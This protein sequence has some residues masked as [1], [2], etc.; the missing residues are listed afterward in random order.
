MN[1]VEGLPTGD[2]SR[3]VDSA[4]RSMG[5]TDNNITLLP[6]KSFWNNRM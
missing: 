2:G 1:S 6:T 4:E 5:D 3:D